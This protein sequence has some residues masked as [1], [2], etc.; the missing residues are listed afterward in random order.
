[1]LKAYQI[2]Y[3]YDQ[4]N[5]LSFPDIYCKA[6]ETTLIIGKSGAGKSTILHLLGG[7]M[8]P[9]NGSIEIEGKDLVK[10][11]GSALDVFRGKNIGIIFQKHHF[12]N[13]LNVEE[14]LMLAQFLGAGSHNVA[15]ISELLD[16]LNIRDKT[17]SKIN[18]LSEGEKQRISIARALINQPK[19]ILADEPTS[20][21]DDENCHIVFTLLK[22][23]AKKVNAALIIVTHDQRL[24]D[25]VEQKISLI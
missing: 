14:N 17:K 18:H 15:K 2:E 6:G 25:L 23:Q 22:E 12:V 13:S 11:R 8:K 10:M 1:M 3:S 9:L 16:S 4:K 21:L 5:Y 20:A 7:L 24:K 19:I